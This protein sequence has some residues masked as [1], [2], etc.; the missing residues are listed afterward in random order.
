MLCS[1]CGDA[2]LPAER[3]WL[4]WCVECDDRNFHGSQELRL[5]EAPPARAA[6]EASVTAPVTDRQRSALVRLHAR[7]AEEARP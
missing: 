6:L 1:I 5:H 3:W 4:D 7:W 2:Y